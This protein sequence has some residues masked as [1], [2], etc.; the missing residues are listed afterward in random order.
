MK[1]FHVI[2]IVLS[3]LILLG[4]G[5]WFAYREEMI[6]A[7]TEVVLYPQSATAVSPE[8]RAEEGMIELW[9]NAL[10]RGIPQ[11]APEGADLIEIPVQ[12]RTV[13]GRFRNAYLLS[14]G[15]MMNRAAYITDL[16]TNETVRLSTTDAEALL[17]HEAFSDLPRRRVPALKITL[18]GDWKELPLSAAPVEKALLL[19]TANGTFREFGAI[20]TEQ[21]E[22]PVFRSTEIPSLISVS[23]EHKPDAW[24]L[25]ILNDFTTVAQLTRVDESK[26]FLP[27][28][29]GTYT[30]KL[31]AHWDLSTQRDWYGEATY[32]F[33]FT[34]LSQAEADS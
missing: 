7:E 34:V 32:E 1:A 10:K 13:G 23:T 29:G 20:A 2:L 4:V 11:E 25:E 9:Q 8:D 22:P 33:H 15:S 26:L 30:Y 19:C 5:G 27:T 18:L 16:K 31:T 14:V 28:E 21:S 24:S 3:A 12:V 17:C 6:F